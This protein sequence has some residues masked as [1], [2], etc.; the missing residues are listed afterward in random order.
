[1]SILDTLVTDRTASD[2]TNRTKKGYYNF[3][4]LNRVQSALLYV[5]EI[6]RGIGVAVSVSATTEWNEN[7]IPSVSDM[8]KYLESVNNVRNAMKMLSTTPQVPDSMS[9]LT[10]QK[11]NDIEK[12]LLDVERVVTEINR[13]FIRA[14]MPWAMAGMEV[15]VRND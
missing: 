2:V 8:E 11:A 15:Y 14:G 6:L 9:K 7:S 4:D 3:E 5:A 13:S 12:I 10:Y 1:M